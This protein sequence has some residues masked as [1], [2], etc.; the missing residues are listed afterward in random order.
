ML[1]VEKMKFIESAE[2]CELIFFNMIEM[3]K[4][5]SMNESNNDMMPSYRIRV[6]E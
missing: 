1:G 4:Q 5:K 6:K 3:E 2:Q